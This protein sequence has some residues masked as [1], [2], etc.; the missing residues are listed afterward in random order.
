MIEK[1]KMFED[2]Q[3]QRGYEAVLHGFWAAKL[4][5]ESFANS[6]QHNY[7]ASIRR[8]NKK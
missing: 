1:Q 6:N 7:Q 8:S 4:T 3:G 5:F 2:M